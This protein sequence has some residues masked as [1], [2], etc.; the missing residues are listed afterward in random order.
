MGLSF[1]KDTPAL[2]VTPERLI[3]AGDIHVGRDLKLRRE[4]IHVPNA[5]MRL[6][7][8]LLGLCK[9]HRAKGI[10]LLG[11]LK[12]SISYPEREE[13]QELSSF[14]YQL[15]NVRVTITKGNHDPRIEEIIERIGSNA[16][17]VRELLLKNVALMH[18]HAMPSEEAMR[19]DYIVTAHSHPAVN[20]NGR[21]EKAWA[22]ARIGGGAGEFYDGYNRKIRLVIMPAFNEL[23]TGSDLSAGRRFTPLFRNGIFNLNKAEIYSLAKKPLGRVEDYV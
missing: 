22:V 10:V 15:R 12:E 9:R 19:H 18:G 16:E 2:L 3:V 20:I 23:I 21:L 7:E 8:S 17:V 11:D 5:T 1:I 14:F 13:L 4:G 6:S